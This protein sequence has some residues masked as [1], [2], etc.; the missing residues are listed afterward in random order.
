MKEEDFQALPKNESSY[1]RNSD[2]G[3]RTILQGNSTDK[4]SQDEELSSINEGSLQTEEIYEQQSHCNG[5]YGIHSLLEDYPKIVEISDEELKRITPDSL[6]EGHLDS[7]GPEGRGIDD[8]IREI[9][10]KRYI[11]CSDDI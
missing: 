4:N 8:V 6:P 11:N 3:E 10:S 9:E 5:L 2:E 1:H 7:P